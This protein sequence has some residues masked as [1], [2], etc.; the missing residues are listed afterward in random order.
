[1]IEVKL[2][3]VLCFTFTVFAFSTSFTVS[4]Y[5]TLFTVFAYSTSFTVLPAQLRLQFLPTQPRLQFLPTQPRLQF[6]RTQPRLQFVYSTLKFS[7]LIL[8]FPS[9]EQRESGAGGGAETAP[10]YK[11]WNGGGSG[12][13]VNADSRPRRRWRRRITWR[14]RWT[15]AAWPTGSS[16]SQAESHQADRTMNHTRA[17]CRGYCKLDAQYTYRDICRGSCKLDRDIC[18]GYCKLYS[19]TETSLGDFAN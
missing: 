16:R 9:L 18:R 7:L 19:F 15:G 10:F 2:Y 13:Q 14:H 17:I 1:M 6:S 3:E 8:V 12:G 4:A 11:C 5:S